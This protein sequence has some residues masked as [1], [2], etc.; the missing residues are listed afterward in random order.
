[1]GIGVGVGF[2]IVLVCVYVN[3]GCHGAHR[4]LYLINS[5][6]WDETSICVSYVYIY[7]FDNEVGVSNV[8]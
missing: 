4:V 1:M 8:L 6:R 2:Y 7:P 3:V 5:F